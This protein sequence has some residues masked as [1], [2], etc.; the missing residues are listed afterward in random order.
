MK[1][2]WIVFRKEMLYTLRDR[3]TLV[4]MVVIPLLL[5]PSIF[6]ITSTIQKSAMESEAGKTLRVAF[7]GEGEKDRL[8]NLLHA[9]PTLRVTTFADTAGFRD[10]IRTDSFDL[11]LATGPGFDGAQKALTSTEVFM[12]YDQTK[13]L[14]FERGKMKVD[15]LSKLLLQERLDSLGLTQ[16]AI[17][18]LKLVKRNT[19][20]T[21]ETIGKMAG[22][23]LPY[24]FIAFCYMGCMFPAIDL[25]TGEKERGTIETILATPV[26]RWK[27]LAGKMLVV[28]CSGMTTAFLAL[29][30]LF[31]GMQLGE[32]LPQELI[33]VVLGVLSPTFMLLFFLMLIPLVTAFAGLMIPA[34]VFAKSYKEA[35]SILSPLNFVV[36]LPAI[37]GMMPGVELNYATACVPVLNV[38]LATK[39]LIAGS[40]NPLHF[41]LTMLSLLIVAA[42]AVLVSFKRFGNESNVLRT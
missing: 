22:G 18:P 35:Q 39:D 17:E 40:I 3:R 19:A 27:L 13:D 26:D 29:F 11:A 7:H 36:I 4:V 25:F 41:I 31:V 21:Q 9:D 30:G 15:F 34:T 5:F 8:L 38:V 42:V 23:F 10:G 12:W 24:I 2:V 37:V 28:V 20:S 32:T 6:V 33:D 14:T 1:H 16:A